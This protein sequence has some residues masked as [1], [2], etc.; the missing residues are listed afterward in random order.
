MRRKAQKNARKFEAHWL[1]PPET[2]DPNLLNN[3]SFN[4][5]RSR[6]SLAWPGRQTHNLEN[7]K[8]GNEGARCPEVAGSNPAPLTEQASA[9]A[10]GTKQSPQLKDTWPSYGQHEDFPLRLSI[11]P[12]LLCNL[13][14]AVRVL[15]LY[16][17]S[18][19]QVTPC[20]PRWERDTQATT[21]TK[22]SEPKPVILRTPS[23]FL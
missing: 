2:I 18:L 6:G 14:N 20:R 19:A 22:N 9:R 4:E 5:T 23:L 10:N 13:N 17:S 21:P 15:S 8:R 16:I 3:R 11:C 12:F 1:K 7:N